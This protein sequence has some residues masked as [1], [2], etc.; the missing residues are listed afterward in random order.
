MDDALMVIREIG[1]DLLISTCLESTSPKASTSTLAHFSSLLTL[2]H[3]K[4]VLLAKA[5]LRI[6]DLAYRRS[7]Y[8]GEDQIFDFKTR[9]GDQTSG[10]ICSIS[11]PLASL[12][13]SPTL[14][15]QVSRS[16]FDPFFML[17]TAA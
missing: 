1:L 9:K 15:N 12:V 5:R 14:R 13:T 7:R 16:C 6:S 8:A 2:D 10:N 11:L 3:L 17:V 4:L